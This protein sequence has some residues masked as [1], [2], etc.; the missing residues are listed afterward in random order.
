MIFYDYLVFLERT[1]IVLIN[2]GVE[3]LHCL[4]IVYEIELQFL[5]HVADSLKVFL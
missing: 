2:V 1:W 4:R 5:R 3:S